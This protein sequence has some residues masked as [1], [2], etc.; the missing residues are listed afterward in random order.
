VK[1]RTE[2]FLK[3]WRKYVR[4]G[5]ADRM[6][7]AEEVCD[8]LLPMVKEEKYTWMFDKFTKDDLEHTAAL[9]IDIL[10]SNELLTDRQESFWSHLLDGVTTHWSTDVYDEKGDVI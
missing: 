4:K 6:V 3:V 10:N 8:V 5:K 2:R 9:I 7:D 1:T